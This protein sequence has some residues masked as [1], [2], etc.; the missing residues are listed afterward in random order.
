M[1]KIN[2]QISIAEEELIFTASHSSGPGGQMSI[3]RQSW[4]SLQADEF[5]TES[6]HFSALISETLKYSPFPFYTLILCK[7]NMLAR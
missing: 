4:K 1:V 5:I 2:E 3:K 7:M 6:Q